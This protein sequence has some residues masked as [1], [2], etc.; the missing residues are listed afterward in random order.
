MSES[1]EQIRAKAATL[2]TRIQNDAAFRALVEQNPEA[3][4][5]AAGLP[6]NAVADVLAEVQAGLGEV[7]AYC[8]IT[9]IGTGVNK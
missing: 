7:S 2:I 1:T 3:T 6:A 8:G 5:V 9:C 4:L